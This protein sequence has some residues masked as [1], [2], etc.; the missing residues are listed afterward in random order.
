MS[1]RLRQKRFR[2]AIIA[3]EDRIT[4]A[5][6]TWT[7]ASSN[8]NNWSNPANWTAISGQDEPFVGETDASVVLTIDD[9]S[10]DQNIQNLILDKLTFGNPGSFTLTLQTPLGIRSSAL[11]PNINNISGTNTITNSTL[12]LSGTAANIRV[13]AGALTIASQITGS[14]GLIKEGEGDLVLTGANVYTGTTTVNAGFL[15]VNGPQPSSAIVLKGDSVLTGAGRV[16]AISTAGSAS[17]ISPGLRRGGASAAATLNTGSLTLTDGTFSPLIFSAANAA[18][19]LAVI[20]TVDLTNA[21]LAPL[22]NGAAIAVGQSFTIISN[23]DGDAV[24]GTFK[25]LPQGSTLTVDGQLFKINYSGGDGNDVVLTA[26]DATTPLPPTPPPSSP[27]SDL[28]SKIVVGGSPDGKFKVVGQDGDAPFVSDPFTAFSNSSNVRSAVGDFNDDGSDDFVLATGPGVP[29]Q[30]VIIDAKTGNVLATFNPFEATF[31]GGLFVAVGDIDKDGIPE[32]VV[33]PDEGG[34]PVIAVYSGAKLMAGEGDNAQIVRFIGIEGDPGFRGGARAALG[35][36]NGDGKVDIVISAG[37]LGGPRIAIFDGSTVEFGTNSPKKL[38]GD[39]SAFEESARNGAFV[40]VGDVNNDKKADLVFG[41]G[42]TSGSRVRLF[43]AA[44]LLGAGAFN[45][46][47]EIAAKAQLA[48]FIAGDES[49]RGGVRVALKD[50]N[51]D[52]NA[53]L[54]TGSGS[55]EASKVRIYL[56]NKLLTTP[57]GAPDFEVDPFGGAVLPNG[58]F[59]G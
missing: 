5:T 30:V 6:H 13:G 42:P 10:S 45:N 9:A 43:D 26:V 29:T 4:P 48:N 51:S 21:S 39:F 11:S 40:S 20:G 33:S 7:D 32:V 44:S 53:D 27:T 22:R 17:A 56:A 8:N 28:S 18:D 58:V 12:N 1:Q 38:I 47:D 16:G 37:V 35:D 34:G 46:V 31:T 14:Q 57:V 23:N 19:Q 49:L 24:V 2:P 41:G 36:V 59:V 55:N 50:Y 54:I 3:L 52:G 25:D 15:Q